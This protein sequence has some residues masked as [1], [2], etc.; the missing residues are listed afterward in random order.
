VEAVRTVASGKPYLSASIAQDLA[1][2]SLAAE[3]SRAD[4]LSAREFEVLRLLVQGVSVRDIAAQ[5]GLT[6]KTV[7]NHQSI[8]R[9][10]LGAETAV[11]LLHAAARLGIETR[12]A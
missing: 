12:S 1:L 9:Q 10:K 5:L 3:A 2:K 8:I 7:A 4:D 6:H 11:Q